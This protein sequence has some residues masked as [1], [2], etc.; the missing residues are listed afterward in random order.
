MRRL[1]ATVLYL[2]T[3]AFALSAL[4]LAG[5]ARRSEERIPDLYEWRRVY[6]YT[7]GLTFGDIAEIGAQYGAQPIGASHELLASSVSGTLASVAVLV[8]GPYFDWFEDDLI[9]GSGITQGMV[10]DAAQ[11]AVISTALAES[12]FLGVQDVLGRTLE[13]IPSTRDGAQAE[14]VV[15]R[16]VGLYEADDSVFGTLSQDIYDRVYIP[17]TTLDLGDI[18]PVDALRYGAEYAVLHN[19]LLTNSSTAFEDLARYYYPIEYAAERASALLPYAVY[20]RIFVLIGALTCFLLLW[21]AGKGILRPFVKP[22]RQAPFPKG[23]GQALLQCAAQCAIYAAALAL[24]FSLLLPSVTI[25]TQGLSSDFF[26]RPSVLA[27]QY[28]SNTQLANTRDAS[29]GNMAT[30]RYAR[31]VALACGILAA[32]SL[33][34][35]LS[36]MLL[37]V[38]AFGAPRPAIL[39][40]LLLLLVL[41][42]VSAVFFGLAALPVGMLLFSLASRRIFSAVQG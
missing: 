22:D 12:L 1:K 24:L 36:V 14:P 28:V 31:Q 6:A 20:L 25:D 30:L 3:A 37:S 15:F 23:R 9:A 8:N 17:Y 34:L 40:Y 4:T 32:L 10:Y 29:A 41:C 21:R 2:L 18:V 11:Y 33:L 26:Y 13:I 38:H 7:G 19:A 35:G 5:I 39:P 27:E 42:I 16:I